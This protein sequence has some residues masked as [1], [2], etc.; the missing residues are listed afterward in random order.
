MQMVSGADWLLLAGPHSSLG[1]F[2]R[3]WLQP[4]AV[5]DLATAIGMAMASPQPTIWRHARGVIALDQPIIMGILNVT[6]DSFSDGGRATTVAAALRHAEQL[7]VGGATI[8]DVGGESTRP[9]AVMVSV[10]E[11][12]TR[13]IPVITALAHQSP[14][15]L[16]SV[17]TVKHQVARAALNAGAAIINDVTAGRHDPQLLEVAGQ[18]GAGL[19]LSHSRGPLESIARIPEHSEP[20]D[21][22]SSVVIELRTAW[23]TARVANVADDCVV[24]DPGLGFGKGTEEN[25]RLLRDLGALVSLGRPVMVGP[26]RKRFLGE[27]TGKGLDEREA[28][29]AAA[30]AIACAHGAAIF[31]VHESAMV[32]DALMVGWQLRCAS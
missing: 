15:V 22:V 24:L 31:R 29:T 10:E 2:A 18:M 25:L 19:V 23:D 21:I 16:I 3:P 6:P 30:C 13:V 11:E 12:L 5:R 20:E 26:S 8:I 17:D 28:A 4:E 14:D 1:A 32:V 9:G 7:M 27:I